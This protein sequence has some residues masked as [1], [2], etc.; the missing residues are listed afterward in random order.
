MRAIAALFVFRL[1][2]GLSMP[3][4]S[5]DERQVYL[6]G[7]RSFARGEWPCFGA[8]VV[9]NGSQLPGALQALLVR[10]PLTIWPAPEAPFVLLNILSAAALAFFAW[11]LARRFADVPRWLIVGLLFTC[12]WTLNF[13]AHIINTS[14]ILP[15]AIVFFVGFFEGAPSFRRGILSIAVAW[16]CMGFGLV[17]MMQIH[18]SWVVLLPFV[19]AAS[20]S[21]V[22]DLRRSTNWIRTIVLAKVGFVAGAALPFA[23]LLPTLMRYGVASLGLTGAIAWQWQSPIGLVTTGARVLSFA[24]FELLR[25]LGLTRADRVLTLWR[26]PWI[27]PFVAIVLVAGIAQ[28]I[29][30]VVTMFRRAR[31][32]AREW[33][34]ARIL[35]VAT[36]V[37][38]YASYFLSIRGQ[39]AH[40]FYLVFPV[41]AFVAVSC[42]DLAARFAGDRRRRWERVA[43]VVF[44]SSVIVH[45]GLGIDRW[46]RQS[47]Y[48]DRPLVA[49]AIADRDDRYLGD[50]RDTIYALE[51]HRPRSIDPVRD[52]DAFLATSAVDDL[53][54]ADQRWEPVAGQASRFFVTIEN[55]SPTVAWL[56]L[57]Y[58]STY[59]DANGVVATQEGVIKRIFEP[60]STQ[61]IE[62]A[63][64]GVPTG[65]TSATLAITT[66]ERA[67]PKSKK[68]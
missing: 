7:L 46:S 17:W 40:A 19:V 21:L 57:R 47:L 18:M 10:W 48:V 23:L 15:G 51:D 39:Q 35:V 29:W 54:I 13:S 56:D 64:G 67:I 33:R 11:Y 32:D 27:A 1:W 28:P 68:P 22:R 4:W 31:G 34:N 53:R 52:A 58:T 26:Q 50:R 60:G 12:P 62:L 25:F 65:A 61:A 14:Y 16:A 38:I 43:I 45:V 63:D 6:I 49:A 30:M 37:L 42:W 59:R 8:D 44:A 36:A 55:R 66:A 24:S 9:W 3:F 41:S 5:E 20:I 2:Y